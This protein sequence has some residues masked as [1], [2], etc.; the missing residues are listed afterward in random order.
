MGLY[1]DQQRDELLRLGY[2]IVSESEHEIVGV[3]SVWHWDVIATNMTYVVFLRATGPLSRANVESEYD[4][5][6]KQ[7]RELDPSRIPRGFQHGRTIVPVY[8][9]DHVEPDAIALIEGPAP[10][11]FAVQLF[12]M[13]LD[14]ST[15]QAHYLRST[16]MWGAAYLPKFRFLAMR[17]LEPESAPDREPVS[18]CGILV[19]V[20][21][22]LLLLFS[23]AAVAFVWYVVSV[24]GSS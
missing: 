17:L 18:G 12:P 11:H 23:C 7:A 2:S 14:R 8:I 13:A 9:A 22:V 21:T 15:G 16:R 1:L 19:T 5:M 4:R 24:L 3:R 6:I 10:M 20:L